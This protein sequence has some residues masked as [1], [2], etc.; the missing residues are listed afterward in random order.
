MLSLFQS[1]ER[2]RDFRDFINIACLHSTTLNEDESITFSADKCL[3][4]DILQAN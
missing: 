1:Y 4:E 3:I 2:L